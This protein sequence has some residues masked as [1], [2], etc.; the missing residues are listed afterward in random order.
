MEIVNQK[1]TAGCFMFFYLMFSVVIFLL[2]MTN[3]SS[4]EEKLLFLFAR[5]KQDEI[6]IG[7]CNK[8]KM[9]VIP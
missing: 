2:K 4:E 1:F 9:K 7:I 3:S 6:K 5:D 8:T